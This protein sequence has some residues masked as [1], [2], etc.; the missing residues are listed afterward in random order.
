MT[1]FSGHDLTCIRGERQVFAGLGFAIDGG[2]ALVLTGPNGSGKSSL[3][4]LMA[5][6]LDPAAGRLSWDGAAIEEDPDAH[7]A[8]VRYLGHADAVK[9]VLSVAENLGFWAGLAGGGDVDGA[10]GAFGIRHLADVPARFLSAGQKRRLALARVV[11]APAPLWL[12]DEPATALDSASIEALRA[13][14]RGHRRTGGMVAVSTH[15]DIGLEDAR[16][17]DLGL[18]EPARAS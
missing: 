11:V 18:L 14:I 5:G 10:L 4:R 13:A 1:R 3:L 15:A 16:G 12:L 9:P 2:E 7:R 6:L 8:R 17:L